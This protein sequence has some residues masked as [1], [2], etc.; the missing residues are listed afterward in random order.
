MNKAQ[1]KMGRY[2]RKEIKKKPGRKPDVSKFEKM[3]D[4]IIERLKSIRSKIKLSN[5]DR[6]FV[7][8]CFQ[9]YGTIKMQDL[10]YDVDTLQF[11]K[12]K[13]FGK[14]NIEK[15][16][17]KVF[18]FSCTEM[19]QYLNP[20]YLNPTHLEPLISKLDLILHYFE[21]GNMKYGANNIRFLYSCPPRSSKTELLTAFCCS[22]LIRNPHL[23]ILYVTNSHTN[24]SSISRKIR[25][26]IEKFG[27]ELSKDQNTKTNWQIDTFPDH[28]DGY[29]DKN[30]ASASGASGV[31]C[32]GGF[33]IF[34]AES[35]PQGI[36]AD[37]L[38]VDDLYK[39]RTDAESKITRDK[40][41]DSILS[42]AM[43]RLRKNSPIIIVS[44]RYHKKDLIGL[45]KDEPKYQYKNLPAINESG[46]SYWPKMWAKSQLDEKRKTMREYAWNALYM[47]KPVPKSG[48]LFEKCNRYNGNIPTG[49]SII[50]GIDLAY[51][52]STKADF[53]TLCEI[54]YNKQTKIY[55]VSNFWRWQDKS[56]VVIPKIK[57]IV[58]NNK[59][60]FYFG[61]TEK[62]VVDLAE[63]SF[64]LKMHA[65]KTTINKADRAQKIVPK[66]HDILFHESIP[67]EIIEEIETFTGQ[68][69]VHD[70]CV[71][72]LVAAILHNEKYANYISPDQ[73]L[74]QYSN[75]RILACR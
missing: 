4:E 50:Y 28:I 33:T 59:P 49:S 10:K 40:I 5:D 66:F 75:V 37:I 22:F 54:Y 72:S 70:D 38:I 2:K 57:N 48:V 60:Y 45:L 30:G 29:I 36:S 73:I 62:A 21:I 32:G 46:E 68:N 1:K 18:S 41:N 3:T 34:T 12:D 19:L 74:N 64:N 16:D 20:T 47:G 26:F 69:G 65:T 24:A 27:A 58:G 6:L 9:K 17:P 8:Q 53:T 63:Q 44:T 14:A 39:S 52:Q 42:N 35:I 67:D 56:T 13:L 43:I 23:T 51:T 61:G 31:R 25:G 55:Y 11:F 15:V 71:D 7:I